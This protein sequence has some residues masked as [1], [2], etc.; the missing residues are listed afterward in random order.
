MPYHTVV[1]FTTILPNHLL[2]LNPSANK[3]VRQKIS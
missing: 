3:F 1:Q 2:W